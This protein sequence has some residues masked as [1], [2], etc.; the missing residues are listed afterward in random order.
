[1][2]W[3]T[4][5][6]ISLIVHAAK[7]EAGSL[8]SCGRSCDTHTHTLAQRKYLNLINYIYKH[9]AKAIK[10]AAHGRAAAARLNV[11]SKTLRQSNRSTKSGQLYFY[12]AARRAVF[13]YPVLRL[14]VEYL[15]VKGVK[16][17]SNDSAS[18]LRI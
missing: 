10:F 13:K 11:C 15:L 12:A 5:R 17:A 9:T 16:Y 2:T 7:E 14:G 4:L 8:V 1:M 3:L 6:F 18:F